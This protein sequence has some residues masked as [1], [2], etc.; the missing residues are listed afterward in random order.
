MIYGLLAVVLFM[1]IYYRKFGLVANLALLANLVIIIGV[2]SMVP[3]ATMT[4]PGIAGIVLTIG[5]SVDANVLIFERIREEL[6]DG[7]SVQQ[8]IHMGYEKAFA[9][10]TD[11]N[12]T[13]FITA[14]ILFAVGT[15][16]IKGFAVTLMIGI[17]ASMFTAIVGTRA[18]VNL[19]WGGKRLKKLSI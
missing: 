19:L 17:L 1:A 11:A 4:L 3:G 13:T 6:R 14:I 15:G 18:L 16:P 5:M 10:I 9:T 7:R 8:A 2:M 12:I